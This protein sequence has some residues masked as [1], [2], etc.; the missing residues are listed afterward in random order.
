[1]SKICDMSVRSHRLHSAAKVLNMMLQAEQVML[2]YVIFAFVN[3]LLLNV[4][5]VVFAIMVVVSATA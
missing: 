5:F 4:V 2:C 3:M 1:M